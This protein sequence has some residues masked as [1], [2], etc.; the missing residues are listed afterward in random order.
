MGILYPIKHQKQRIPPIIHVQYS[1]NHGVD[2]AGKSI[3][4]RTAF[5]LAC[6]AEPA[7]H[8]YDRELRRLEEKKRAGAEL[9]MTQPVYD[10]DVLRRFLN[11]ARSL[12]LPILV[13]LCPLASSRNAEFLHNEVPGMQIPE[14]IRRRMAA[15][16][17]PDEERGRG[18]EVAREMLLQVKDDVVGAYLMPQFGRFR[19]A[20]EVLQVIGYEFAPEDRSGG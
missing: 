9:V 11:D 20:V 15:A 3:E 4:D 13:G 16:G 5:L 10:P 19:T 8:D 6:G 18:V 14:P 1:L 17:T 7:A 12:D 2:P